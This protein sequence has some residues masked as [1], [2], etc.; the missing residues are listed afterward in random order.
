MPRRRAGT[1]AAGAAVESVFAVAQ[2]AGRGARLPRARPARW[3]PFV[4]QRRRQ[5]AR[6]PRPDRWLGPAWRMPARVPAERRRASPPRERVGGPLPAQHPTGGRHLIAASSTEPAPPPRELSVTTLNSTIAHAMLRAL[7]PHAGALVVDP[8]AGCGTL[9]ELSR[10]WGARHSTSAA[11]RASSSRETARPSPSPRRA[12]TSALLE[13]PVAVLCSMWCSGTRG[14]CRCPPSAWTT[15][16]ATCPLVSASAPRLITGG[17]IRRRSSRCDA[18]C[19]P[20][21]ALPPRSSSRRGVRRPTAP[22][23]GARRA[24]MGRRR[25]L[26]G[27]STRRLSWYCSR[28]TDDGGPRR[29]WQ[30]VA[31]GAAAARQRGRA[32]RAAA[33]RQARRRRARP[34]RRWVGLHR[35]NIRA[36]ARCR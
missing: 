35:A 30:T 5:A 12:P 13:R 7:R 32:R 28:Q 2:C 11:H 24:R 22:P 10:S 8:M 14:G 15:S 31:R 18:R 25:A 36:F 21:P 3:V 9:P 1:R 26:R 17:S 19:G 33:W 27:S 29:A 23:R 16:S 20:P 4:Q 6:R 34:R